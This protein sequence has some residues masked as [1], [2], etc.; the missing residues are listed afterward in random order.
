MDRQGEEN[1][2]GGQ[3]W[4]ADNGKVQ[5]DQSCTFDDAI[6]EFL[7]GENANEQTLQEQEPI[8][9]NGNE[10]RVLQST[11]TRADKNPRQS[12]QQPTT[13]AASIATSTA[14]WT[15]QGRGL[16][17][18]DICRSAEQTTEVST[19]MKFRYINSFIC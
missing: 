16:H 12:N 2:Q 15:P 13:S 6:E 5:S 7:N 4:E 17:T 11:T 3:V 8:V 14:Q 18:K 1:H 19:N 10:L 9:Y